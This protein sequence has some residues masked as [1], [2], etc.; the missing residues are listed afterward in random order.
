MSLM[1]L[2]DRD[3]PVRPLPGSEGRRSSESRTES[4]GGGGGDTRGEAA[5]EGAVTRFSTDSGYMWGLARLS[6]AL[7]TLVPPTRALVDGLVLLLPPSPSVRQLRLR[8][9]LD[10]ILERAT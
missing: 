9:V 5:V 7:A 2:S 6:R 4:G 10:S 8:T 1:S 3:L